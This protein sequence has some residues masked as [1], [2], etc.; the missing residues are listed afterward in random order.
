MIMANK[1]DNLKSYKKGQCGNP[2]GRPRKLPKLD[3]LMASVLGEERDGVTAAETILRAMR[4]KAARGDVKAA[5]LL[6]DRGFGKVKEQIELSGE[7]KVIVP[8]ED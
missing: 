5:S 6:L 2:N 7:I 8:D 3:E 1:L 4:L